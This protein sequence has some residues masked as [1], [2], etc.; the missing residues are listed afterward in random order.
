[1]SIKFSQFNAVSSISSSGYIVGYD[2]AN[3][4]R[5]KTSTAD[6]L[7][8]FTGGSLQFVQ[9]TNSMVPLNTIALDKLVKVTDVS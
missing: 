4:I 2:G 9:L 8:V 6:R 7:F 3:N 5:I 1:M